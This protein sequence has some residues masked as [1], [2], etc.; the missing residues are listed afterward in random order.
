MDTDF[1]EEEIKEALIECKIPVIKLNRMVR[2]RDGIPTPL[3]MYY[4]ETPNTPDGKRMYDIRYLLDM[5]VRIVT[6][7]GR[8]G[9]VQ[10][11]QCQRF[12]HT[13]KAC[14]NK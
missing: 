14:H 6:Y 2:M 7:K 3:P 11:F 10:C 9:P 8:P 13:Q 5:R 1:S 12:G 4:L